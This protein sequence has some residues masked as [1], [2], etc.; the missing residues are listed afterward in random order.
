MH[1]SHIFPL[2]RG[3]IICRDSQASARKIYMV[4]MYRVVRTDRRLSGLVNE[5]LAYSILTVLKAFFSF[6][7]GSVIRTSEIF[8]KMI[9]FFASV[10]FLPKIS[11]IRLVARVTRRA[12]RNETVPAFGPRCS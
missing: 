4:S 8:F 12:R 6:F 3:K 5:A 2:I 11:V 9:N 10:S 1:H 7:K